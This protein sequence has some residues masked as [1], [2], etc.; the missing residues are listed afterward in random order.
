MKTT[1]PD[2]W[3]KNLPVVQPDTFGGIRPC[4]CKPR[5]PRRPREPR[6]QIIPS[7]TVYDRGEMIREKISQCNES[8]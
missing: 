8:E 4:K 2:W 5:E 3:M 6:H 1:V 7:A